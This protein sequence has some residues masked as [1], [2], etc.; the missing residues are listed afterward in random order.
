METQQGTAIEVLDLSIRAYNCL[1]RSGITTVEQVAALSD[2]ELLNIRNVGVK[3]LSEIQEKLAAYLVKY[4]L[5]ERL[6]EVH[7]EISSDHDP[8]SLVDSGL[9]EQPESIGVL[10]LS[11]RSHNRLQQAGIDTVERLADMTDADLLDIPS[12]GATALAEIRGKLTDYLVNHPL[13][14]QPVSI[15]VLGL[16]SRSH[17]LLR[18]NGIRTLAQLV[19]LS[20]EQIRNLRNAGEKTVKEIK[21]KLEAYL[22]KHP[23]SLS[24]QLVSDKPLPP[25][26]PPVPVDKTEPLPPLV[27]PTLLAPATQ[28]PLENISLDRLA[29]PLHIHNQLRRRGIRSVGELARQPADIFDLASPVRVQLIRYITWLVEQREDAWEDEVAGR[30]ISPLYHLMLAEITLDD[31]VTQWLEVLTE[32]EHQILRWRYGFIDEALTLEEIGQLVNLTRERVRQIEAKAIRKLCRPSQRYIVQSLVQ[33]VREVLLEGGGVGTETQIS[34]TVSEAID[35]GAV[36]PQGVVRLLLSIH[37]EFAEIKKERAWGLTDLPLESVAKINRYAVDLLAAERAPLTKDELLARLKV[38]PWYQ[39]HASQ[40]S[41]AFILACIN[42]SEKIICREDES[43]GLEK[44]QR[45]YLDDIIVALRRL[46][47]PAHYSEIAETIN[48]SLPEDQHITPRAVHIRLMQHPE[49]FVWVGR[50]G[51][52]GLK[53]WGVKRALSY[54]KTLVGILRRAGHPL[55]FQQILAQ[56]PTF[57]PYYD[58]NSIVLTLGTNERFR[59]F[60]DDT[61]G[62]AEW[63]EEDFT[64]DYRLQRMFDGVETIPSTIRP[65]TR[66]I[67]AM[68]GVD[69]FIAR[70]RE[71]ANDGY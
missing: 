52:Y 39:E 30:G 40:L 9:P 41:D 70:V 68:D 51:T 27:D 3:V 10:G 37:D 14:E 38:M 26:Q 48:A 69:S 61:Y 44:W 65:K 28:I 36:D 49:L 29:L 25:P 59:S 45:H 23:L 67:E 53:E 24:E 32:R 15:E 5:P 1:Q 11:R 16:S 46:S 35:I 56:L 43:Y 13:P 7:P 12:L 20:S 47:Q 42:V 17:N 8:T 55:T 33:F 64:E 21:K 60:P 22:A 18:R 66:V 57:R 63:R 71:R 4:P 54:E 58:E 34:E 62:L 50:R 19:L 6:G 2:D 31:L